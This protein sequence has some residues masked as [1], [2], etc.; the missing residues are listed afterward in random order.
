MLAVESGEIAAMITA[1]E[2]AQSQQSEIMTLE[3]HLENANSKFESQAAQLRTS[4]TEY[5]ALVASLQDICRT[6]R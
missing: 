1:L 2:A 4:K 3:N 5:D 6:A